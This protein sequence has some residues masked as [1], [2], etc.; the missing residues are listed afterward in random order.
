[1]QDTNRITGYLIITASIILGVGSLLAFL[2][3]LYTGKIFP[4]DTGMEGI[5]LLAFDCALSLMFFIQHSFMVRKGFKEWISRLINPVYYSAVYSIFSGISLFLMVFLWQTSDIIIL[6]PPDWLTWFSR[7]IFL[8]SICGF[9]WGIR[10]LGS[11][12]PYGLGSIR[13]AMKGKTT[14]M[15]PF[16]VKGPYRYVR[17]PLYLFFLILI[18]SNPSLTADRLL[19]N[20]LWTLW[21][22]I[23]TF[24]EER[25]LVSA[26]GEEYRDYQKKVPM[27]IPGRKRWD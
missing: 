3:F 16:T 10:S 8:L 20:I 6:A 7:I 23:G 11:F 9:I 27:L 18:W 1:M 25:D 14:L 15:I 12:D 22:I 17:H 21:I 5:T 13:R 4:V 24:L 19:L 2:L 26:Y